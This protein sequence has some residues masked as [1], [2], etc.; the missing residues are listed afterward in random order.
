MDVTSADGTKLAVWRIARR[1]D[2]DP[3]DGR[4][5]SYAPPRRASDLDLVADTLRGFFREIAPYDSRRCRV[6][7]RFQ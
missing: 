4:T 7:G 2:A 3:D 1:G 6:R 5:R